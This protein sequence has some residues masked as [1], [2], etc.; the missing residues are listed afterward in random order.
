M[1]NILQSL[2]TLLFGFIAAL[3]LIQYNEHQTP[4]L[5]VEASP[6][7]PHE[8]PSPAVLA[9]DISSTVVERLEDAAF[10]KKVNVKLI[11]LE[12]RTTR[13]EKELGLSNQWSAAQ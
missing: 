5:S 9:N 11:R 7:P 13:I 2:N 1:S 4:L 12:T 6:P 8:F 10:L 3:L